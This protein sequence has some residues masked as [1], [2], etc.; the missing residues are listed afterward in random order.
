VHY[1]VK[2]DR[3]EP[4]YWIV[5]E[6]Y[7]QRAGFTVLRRFVTEQAAIEECVRLTKRMR[8]RQLSLIRVSKISGPNENSRLTS[9]P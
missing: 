1:V 6:C 3:Y 8:E 5:G 2:L 4:G 7:E 9:G